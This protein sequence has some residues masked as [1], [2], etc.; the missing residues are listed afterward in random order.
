LAK[1]S[2][3][4]YF[5]TGNAGKFREIQAVIPEIQQLKLDLDE[6]QSLDPQVVIEHKLTQ[7]AAHHDG[8]FIVE[9]TML[10]FGCIK[11]LP[12]T[13]V[14]WFLDA[15]RPAGLAE[16]VT[17]YEDHS[18][19]SQVTIGYRDTGGATHYFSAQHHGQIVAPRGENGF[20]FDS[21]F[22]A[23]G[24]TKTNAELSADEKNAFSAR[25]QA[26]RQLAAHLATSA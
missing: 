19:T 5:I 1:P 3:S 2:A 16:L 10:T 23:D 18:V 4:L 26:A 14:K 12:G 15:L 22:L 17:H 25:G 7:A 20:G 8:T 11:P 24:Q 21:I 9:D 13:F 6:I